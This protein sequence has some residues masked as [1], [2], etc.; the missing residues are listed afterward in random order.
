[1]RVAHLIS[2]DLT[3]FSGLNLYTVCKFI[4]YSGAIRSRMMPANNTVNTAA[5]I[6]RNYSKM[7]VVALPTAQKTT[8]NDG[9]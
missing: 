7:E 1:M 3:K 9:D 4:A 6:I 5:E 8:P 2:K